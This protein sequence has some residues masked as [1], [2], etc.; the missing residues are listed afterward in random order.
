MRTSLGFALWAVAGAGVALG[1]LTAP[2]I[3]IFVLPAALVLG[4]LLAWRGQRWLAGP[5]VVAG[6]G[7]PL[8]YVGYLNRGGP[9]TVCA[10]PSAPAPVEGGAGSCMQEWSPWPW[11]AAGLLLA[12]AGVVL[13]LA[14]ARRRQP[15]RPG[16]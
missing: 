12:V 2:T 1:L 7:L 10:G 16:L 14:A 3:G 5:G 8:L 13:A 4:S 15:A 6:L 9:G 11:I